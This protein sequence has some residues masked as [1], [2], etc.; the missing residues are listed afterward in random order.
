MIFEFWRCPASNA[1]NCLDALERCED[2]D[3]HLW[4]RLVST[5]GSLD[6]L[7]GGDTGLDY[8]IDLTA[9]KYI[10]TFARQNYGIVLVDLPS[11]INAASIHILQ[12]SQRIFVVT[13][14]DIASVHIAKVRW[15]Q[16]QNLDLAGN[17]FLILNRQGKADG[18]TAAEI[19]NIVG[20]PLYGSFANDGEAV[21][22]ALLS[23]SKISTGY[24]LGRELSTFAESLRNGPVANQPRKKGRFSDLF[25]IPKMPVV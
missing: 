23:G 15:L 9:L 13:A 22:N 20:V 25:V 3:E 1:R 24:K 21:Q 4:F 5:I 2:L 6:V 7:Q 10:M 11:A 12:Q 14:P 19:K 17:A 16:L 18:I 8:K